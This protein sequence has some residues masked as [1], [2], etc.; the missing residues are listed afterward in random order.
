VSSDVSPRPVHARPA[1]RVEDVLALT[2]RGVTVRTTLAEGAPCFEG[3]YPGYPI[4][5]G[6]FCVELVHQA[7]RLYCAA[8]LPNGRLARVGARFLAP[9]LPGAVVCSECSCKRLPGELEFK[10]VCR[11]GD[12]TVAE[13]KLVL[14]ERSR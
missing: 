10:G 3:H 13:V 7:A 11:V 14:D 6:V 12:R 4:F 8:Y 5:P 1:V 9:V 2:E